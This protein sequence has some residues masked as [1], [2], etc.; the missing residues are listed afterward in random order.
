MIEYVAFSPPITGKPEISAW[1][2]RRTVVAEERGARDERN[3]ARLKIVASTHPEYPVGTTLMRC[4]SRFEDAYEDGGR[5]FR[6]SSDT[7]LHTE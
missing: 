1:D 3:H 4:A 6:E 5:F 2:P 7:E